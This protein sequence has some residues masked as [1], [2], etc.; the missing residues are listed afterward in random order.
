MGWIRELQEGKLEQDAD[1]TGE[2][3]AKMQAQPWLAVAPA[4]SSRNKLD[5]MGFCLVV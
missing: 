1:R 2:K 4:G 5:K 3:L